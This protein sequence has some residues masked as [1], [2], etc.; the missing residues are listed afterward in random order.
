MPRDARA[1]IADIIDSCDAIAVAMN[2]IDL[3]AYKAN[4]LVR[5]AVKREFTIIGEAMSVLS[6]NAP[7][8]FASITNARRIVDFRNQLAHQ[9]PTVNDVLVWGIADRDVPTLREE[10]VALMHDLAGG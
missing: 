3:N 4:R 10:C 6:R 7:G 9:Y 8:L 1:Y 5:S 2:G